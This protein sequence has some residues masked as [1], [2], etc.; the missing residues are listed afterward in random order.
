MSSPAHT[1]VLVFEDPASTVNIREV[2]VTDPA[3]EVVAVYNNT[4]AHNPFVI[5]VDKAKVAS[6]LGRRQAVGTELLGLLANKL[7]SQE[8]DLVMSREELE[9]LLRQAGEDTTFRPQVYDLDITAGPEG[10][11]PGGPGYEELGE[12]S[13]Q[14]QVAQV[15]DY[16]QEDLGIQDPVGEQSVIS[17]KVQS[18]EAA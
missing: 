17:L 13:A 4:K 18:D 10:P 6:R 7:Q 16:Q 2:L 14:D 12:I 9:N 3:I 1:V 11:P 15:T 8:G 5:Q